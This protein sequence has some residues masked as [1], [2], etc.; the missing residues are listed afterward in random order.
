MPLAAERLSEI[1]VQL[2]SR[3]GHEMVRALVFELLVHG[4]GARSSDV[5]FER[6]APEVHGRIDALLGRTIFEF[7]SDLRQ[8]ESDAEEQLTRYLRDR[9]SETGHRY[10]GIATD[11]V[12]FVPFELRG[13]TLR[14]LGSHRAS[15]E[16]P[17]GLLHWLSSAVS[18]TADLEPTPEVVA[19]ELGRGSLAWRVARSTLGELW[20]E[21][22]DRPDVLVKRQLWAQLLYRVYGSSV[23]DDDLFFQHTYLSVVAKTMAMH[24]LG[25]DTAEPSDLLAGEPFHGIGIDGVVESDFF[26]WLL[27]A[28]GGADLVRRVANQAARFRLADV[29]TDVLK[30]LYESLIDPDQR[31][32]L[33][34]YYTPDW[35]AARMCEHVIED[36]LQERVVDPA[37][38]S[39][40][41]LFHGVRR[42]LAAADQAG[43]DDRQAL[44]L[45][46]R[47][48]IGIDVHPVAVQ[49]ARV[50]YMLAIGEQRLR[51]RPRM[52]I[53]VYMG[54][55]IQWNTE[56]VLADREVLIEVPDGPVLHFPFGITRDPAVFDRVIQSMLDMS[57]QDSSGEAF[58][59][60][61]SRDIGVDQQSTAVLVDT[62]ESIRSLQQQNR[63]HVWGFFARNLSRPVWLS[64]PEERADVVIGNPPWLSYRFMSGETQVKFRDECVERGLWVGGKVATHQDISAYFFARCAELYLRPTGKIAFV[65]PYAAM[66][67]RQFTTFRNGVFGRRRRGKIEHLFAAVRFTEAWA[68]NDSVRPLFPVPSCVLFAELANGEGAPTPDTVLAFSGTLPRRDAAPAESQAALTANRVPWPRSGEHDDGSPYRAAFRQ[69]ATM[70]PRMLCTVEYVP[71]RFG[72]AYDSPWVQSRRSAQ[73]KRPWK[74]LPSVRENVEAEFVRPLYL[75]E[76]IAPY[77]PLEPVLSVIPFD[78]ETG[79][80][81]DAKAMQESGRRF[82][83]R[84]LRQAERL[85]S[86]HGS[87]KQSFIEQID[88]FNKLSAQLP[89]TPLRVV[90]TKAGSLVS[91]A[92]VRD[93]VALIDHKLYWAS[94]SSDDE[95]RYLLSILNSEAVR[96]R[97]EQFQ[98]R[99]QWGAR[100][101]DKVIF[102]LP[103]PS[104]DAS[105]RIHQD[106]AAAGAIAERMANGVALREGEYFTRSRRKIREALAD[107]GIA[108][109]ID[110][111]V[112]TLLASV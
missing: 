38:G 41:F 72:M 33:G 84:W 69:G 78:R 28:G 100:D 25:L 40:A 1:T 105:L 66:S 109:Q 13:E 9:E 71:S 37:C 44:E 74:D 95:A 45:C 16:E 42:F 22:G 61:I 94:I 103:I 10:V 77:R 3:P 29:R 47:R 88:Y 75:G 57:A 50:T 73:E 34:E 53:P 20:R 64:S 19:Q 14:R 99:G 52:A 102:N 35:L 32:D 110:A 6:P 12:D 11:G 30:G 18:V 49:I 87:G 59:G 55:S 31:H 106:L 96:S 97:I 80:L 5:Q 46:C 70:V 79:R 60:W 39:G 51:D 8:E 21:A 63:D 85:W 4:L 90:Y 107:D 7:K 76:S 65:M 23:D 68:F 15:L 81:L 91:A 89:T 56:P 48:V 108:S 82:I 67:R 62:Y 86:E 112:E 27:A 17:T 104:F 83:P 93:Q 24:V 111:L 43:M 92:I 101:I 54:D 26:D 98:S 2:A 58:G 36:P